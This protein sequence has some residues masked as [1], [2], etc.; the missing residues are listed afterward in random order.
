VAPFYALKILSEGYFPPNL[1]ILEYEVVTILHIIH[2]EPW[3][4]QFATH[5]SV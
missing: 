3:D 4:E 5:N 2:K 1:V